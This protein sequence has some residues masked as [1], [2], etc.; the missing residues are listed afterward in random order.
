MPSTPMSIKPPLR[1][2]LRPDDSAPLSEM[3]PSSLAA[4]A[5]AAAAA[6]SNVTCDLLCLVWALAASEGTMAPCW[7]WS[8]FVRCSIR[9]SYTHTHTHTHMFS[10]WTYTHTHTHTHTHTYT[11]VDLFSDDLVRLLLLLPLPFGC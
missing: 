9:A 10:A 3:E 6:D 5:A 2:V 1:G 8:C 7:S 11:H 4:A